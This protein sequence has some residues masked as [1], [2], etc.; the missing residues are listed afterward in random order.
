ML[1]HNGMF[2]IRPGKMHSDFFVHARPARSLEKEC[3]NLLVVLFQFGEVVC[4]M[5][6]TG[7]QKWIADLS[8]TL[9]LDTPKKGGWERC[10]QRETAS[11]L[12]SPIH[13]NSKGTLS[14]AV[15]GSHSTISA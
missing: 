7:M 6:S 4:C 9:L 15:W 1:S 8:A 14:E 13:G 11:K 2:M 12:P 5:K 10:C 3:N